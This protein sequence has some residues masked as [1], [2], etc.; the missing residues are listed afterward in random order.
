MDR[1]TQQT[2]FSEFISSRTIP[3]ISES[4]LQLALFLAPGFFVETK[5]FQQEKIDLIQNLR[6]NSE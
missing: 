5:H 1:K 6:L 2:L 4:E 3:K